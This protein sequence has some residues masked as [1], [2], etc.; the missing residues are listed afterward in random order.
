MEQRNEKLCYN[1]GYFPCERE[2][3]GFWPGEKTLKRKL[4]FPEGGGLHQRN[5]ALSLSAPRLTWAKKYQLLG[6]Y[7]AYSNNQQLRKGQIVKKHLW[8]LSLYTCGFCTSF[9]LRWLWISR[10]A[11]GGLLW[12]CTT[13]RDGIPYF[14]E[15]PNTA[16]GLPLRR[17]CTWSPG[18]IQLR[19]LK[20][21][22]LR[23]EETDFKKHSLVTRARTAQTEEK[24]SDTIKLAG[25]H[26]R[27]KQR[28]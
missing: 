7:H 11:P 1:W 21:R 23:N 17:L 15:G 16:M 10:K 4:L 12:N 18:L 9:S 26:K 24:I 14:I 27:G 5:M 22:K 8:D 19:A 20:T 3:S 25:A 13:T 6:W 28:W 2:S